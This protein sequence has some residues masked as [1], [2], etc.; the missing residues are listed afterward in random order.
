MVATLGSDAIR[1]PIRLVGAEIHPFEVAFFPDVFG[2]LVLVPVVRSARLF[3]LAA[4]ASH[5]HAIP[6]LL[7]AGAMLRWF[8]GV[9][10]APLATVAAPSFLALLFA[11]LLAALVLRERVA[12]RRLAAV[13][14][15]RGEALLVL[16]PGLQRPKFGEILVT[17]SSLGPGRSSTSRSWRAAS[18]ACG[19]P[20]TLPCSRCRSRSPRRRSSGSVRRPALWRSSS[21]S[22]PSA[23]WVGWGR[24]GLPRCRCCP[25]PAG[26]FHRARLGGLA[27]LVSLRGQPDPFARIG[28]TIV[29]GA[30]LCSVLREARLRR[31]DPRDRPR[32]RL[33]RSARRGSRRDPERD[34]R[35]ASGRPRG[36]ARSVGRR[37][38]RA[39]RCGLPFPR[40]H[41]RRRVP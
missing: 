21:R 39:P 11:T 29:C 1:A 16:R 40:P 26:R 15:D 33:S 2:L 34:G 32:A 36:P 30:L 31:R 41:W 8:Y 38:D 5:L 35:A 17:S 19:S 28:G 7:D 18:R 20:S 12:P 23:A 14:I 4:A 6:G 3:S 24:P 9:T 25:G 37:P 22:R 10:L 13:L 27:R